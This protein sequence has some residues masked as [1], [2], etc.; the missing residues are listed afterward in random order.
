LNHP[1]SGSDDAAPPSKPILILVSGMPAT[2]KSTLAEALGE[3][4]GWPLFTKDSFKELLYDAGSYDEES[5]DE[6][7][8]ETV[9]AQAIA[10]LRVT[11]TA[12]VRAGLHVILEANFRAS[13][14]ARDFAPFLAAAEVRQVYCTLEIEDVLERYQTRL[15][16]GERHPVHVDSTDDAELE[17][18]LRTKD[19]DPLPLDIPTLIVDTSDGFDPP[20]ADI[21]A[22]C[23]QAA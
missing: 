6:E 3:G 8:S 19:Y 23:R 5:F 13:L 17:T 1:A 22:F 12:L 16:R 21:I 18:E 2:G 14:A 9:G 20:L 11:A 4:L 10:L 7:A 15:D